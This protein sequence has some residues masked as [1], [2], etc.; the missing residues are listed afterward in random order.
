MLFALETRFAASGTDWAAFNRK[1][2]SAMLL[3]R[4]LEGSA[5]RDEWTSEPE[6]RAWE[7]CQAAP[8]S[9]R[10]PILAL[11]YR[12]CF[13]PRG[14]STVQEQELTARVEEWIRRTDDAG[15][16]AA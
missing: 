1:R 2:G 16:Q 9:V 10:G 5:E 4:M 7:A 12:A 11:H 14:L 6:V 3:G 15:G 13:H 8:E